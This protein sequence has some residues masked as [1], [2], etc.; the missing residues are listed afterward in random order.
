MISDTNV[1][2]IDPELEPFISMFPQTNLDDPTAARRQ[3][4]ELSARAP[5]PDLDG[6]KVEDR[7]APGTPQVPVRIYRPDGPRARSCGCTAAAS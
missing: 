3:L 1:R 5:A 7:M 4:A 6:T 2:R